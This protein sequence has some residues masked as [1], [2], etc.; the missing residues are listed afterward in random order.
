MKPGPRTQPASEDVRAEQHLAQVST[1]TASDPVRALDALDYVRR[2][3]AVDRR[4]GRFDDWAR[5]T[6]VDENT[7]EPVLAAGVL[8]SLGR[9]AGVEVRYPYANA[10]LAHTYGYLLSPAAT[11]YG[12][13]RARWTQGALAQAFGCDPHHFQPWRVPAGDSLLGRVTACAL[14]VALGSRSEH[15][16]HRR[17]DPDGYGGQLVTVI[18]R[19]PGASSAALVYSHVIDGRARLVTTFPVDAGVDS[20]TRVAGLPRVPRYNVAVGPWPS[21]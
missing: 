17:D 12:P 9:L 14:P 4:T 21:R 1:W 10:G 11:P 7:G 16:L 18:W 19:S 8:E 6:V 2:Q 15:V 5:S 3:I 13:K 20:L